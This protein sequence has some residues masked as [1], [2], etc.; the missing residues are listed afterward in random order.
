M[1][2]YKIKAIKKELGETASRSE[3][4]GVLQQYFYNFF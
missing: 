1:K 4:N 3:W 2:A